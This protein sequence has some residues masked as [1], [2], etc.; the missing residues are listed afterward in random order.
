MKKSDNIAI[1]EEIQKKIYAHLDNKKSF[2]FKAGAGAGK[3]YALV[4]SI[5]YIMKNNKMHENEKLVCITYT[6]NAVNEIKERIG[7][8]TNVT[9]ST[10]HDFVWSICE[11][12]QKELREEHKIKVK[13]KM[14]SLYEQIEVFEGEKPNETLRKEEMETLCGHNDYYKKRRASDTKELV[15]ELFG[16]KP[17][18]SESFRKYISNYRDYISLYEYYSNDEFG[19]ITYDTMIGRDYL[20]KEKISH[21]TMIEY[22]TQIICES[23]ILQRIIVDRFPYIFIDEC[24]DTLVQVVEAFNKIEVSCSKACFGYFGDFKQKIYDK[25]IGRDLEKKHVGLEIVN[26]QINRRSSDEIINLGNQLMLDTNENQVSMFEGQIGEVNVS[27]CKND[28]ELHEKIDNIDVTGDNVKLYLTNNMIYTDIGMGN[29]YDFFKDENKAYRGSNFSLVNTETLSEEKTKLG[30]I[31]KFCFEL[32]KPFRM[33]ESD[34]LS[35]Y[36]PKEMV[37][38]LSIINL[39]EELNAI[40]SLTPN[41]VG[42]IIE[43]YSNNPEYCICKLNLKNTRNNSETIEEIIYEVLGEVFPDDYVKKYPKFLDINIEEVWSWMQYLEDKKTG[44]ANVYTIHGSKGLEFDKVTL[45]LTD[46]FGGRNNNKIKN[47]IKS[48]SERNLLEKLHESAYEEEIL[49]L[50]YVGVTRAKSKLNIVYRTEC[51]EPW[52]ENIELIYSKL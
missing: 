3:T 36:I 15:N 22:C 26:K 10:I 11:P 29:L 6:N 38:S 21:D 1:E 40:L 47:T 35:E 43:F 7:E 41:N 31:Q 39:R 45:V 32:F 25:G 46:S 27:F 44:M 42:D 33:E 34:L 2:L 18:S 5:K 52:M 49:N 8:S 37:T 17:T 20:E 12:Y 24:Q 30:I 9:V 4:E 48:A 28:V 51:I 19:T 13:D 23:K 14:D 16:F 50:L